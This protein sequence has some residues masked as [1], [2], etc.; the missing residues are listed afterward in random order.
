MDAF[1]GMK[2]AFAISAALYGRAKTKKGTQIFVSMKGV[3]FDLLEQN[4]I[5]TSVT[6]VNPAKVGNMDNAI[7]PFGLFK[8]KNGS[9]ALA[10]GNEKLWQNITT[11]LIKNNAE[12]DTAKFATNS[13]R[14]KNTTELQNL[15]ESVFVN[16]DTSELS[17]QL[18]EM[19]IPSGQVKTMKDVLSDKENFE[20]KLLM[21]VHAQFHSFVVPTGGISFSTFA[22]SEYRMAPKN[23]HTD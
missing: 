4:L 11:F 22:Q 5:E 9:I 12:V 13:L 18:S 14:L 7:A 17:E 19:G 10:A 15:I 23:E 1:G 2:L 3:A 6:G 8:T 20:Q 21:N 16:F